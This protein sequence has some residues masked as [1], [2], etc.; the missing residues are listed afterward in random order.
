MRAIASLCLLVFYVSA[1][2]Y[3]F[4]DRAESSLCRMGLET[5]R[6]LHD[7]NL[8][9]FQLSIVQ[10]RRACFDARED[11]WLRITSTASPQAEAP[12]QT[13]G[14][15]TTPARNVAA[16]PRKLSKAGEKI[17]SPVTSIQDNVPPPSFIDLTKNEV[18]ALIGV[19][20][21]KTQLSAIELHVKDYKMSIPGDQARA[22]LVLLRSAEGEL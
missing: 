7:N 8:K 22:L 2:I 12:S 17:A 16:G 3:E 21:K 10:R 13:D 14:G 19:V 11:A 6:V 15:T 9:G 1:S 4:V 5:V 18:K 20:E